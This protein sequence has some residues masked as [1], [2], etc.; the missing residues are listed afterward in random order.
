MCVCARVYIYICIYIYTHLYSCLGKPGIYTRR[1]LFMYACIYAFLD[2]TCIHTH[3]YS[4]PSRLYA[5][6]HFNNPRFLCDRNQRLKHTHIRIHIL[7]HHMHTHTNMELAYTHTSIY[8]HIHIQIHIH[9]TVHKAVHFGPALRE[10][11]RQ[12]ETYSC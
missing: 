8:T 7:I 3:P 12:Q 6:I 9:I 5:Y 2:S 11:G 4:H 10:P 1:S